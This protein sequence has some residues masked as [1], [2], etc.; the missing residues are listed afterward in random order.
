[1]GKVDFTFGSFFVH[2]KVNYPSKTECIRFG[3]AQFP[4]NFITRPPSDRFKRIGL[5]TQ[6]KCCVTHTQA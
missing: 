3:Q 4:P 6:E 1:M 2:R 5:A